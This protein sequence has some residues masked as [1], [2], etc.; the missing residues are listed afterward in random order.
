MNPAMPP[1]YQGDL[2]D[3]NS[4]LYKKYGSEIMDKYKG[5]I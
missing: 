3:Q 5:M 1:M 2:Y 4:Y